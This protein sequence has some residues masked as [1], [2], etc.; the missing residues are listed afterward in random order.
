MEKK[1]GDLAFYFRA[2][3]PTQQASQLLDLSPRDHHDSVDWSHSRLADAY[4]E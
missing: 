2:H 3:P 1:Q 4:A